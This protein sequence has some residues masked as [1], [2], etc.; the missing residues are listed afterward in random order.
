MD[1]LKNNFY[2]HY[3]GKQLQIGDR[4]GTLGDRSGTIGN[5][6]PI[7]SVYGKFKN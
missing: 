4:S 1:F 3:K 5:R 2:V 6:F 7:R